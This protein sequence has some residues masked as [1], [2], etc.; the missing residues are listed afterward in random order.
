MTDS[1]THR[2]TLVKSR[3]RHKWLVGV[4]LFLLI[5]LAA[6]AGDYAGLLRWIGYLAIVAGVVGRIWASIYVAGRKNDE[7]VALGPYSVVRNPLYVFSFLGVAG[8]GLAT[9]MASVALLLTL[10]FA[11][12]YPFVIR[13]EERFLESRFGDTYRAYKARVP[14]WFPKMSLWESPRELPIRLDL[15]WKTTR[16]AA[17]WFLL[18][19]AFALLHWVYETGLA[20][21]L[22]RLP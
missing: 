11:V 5:L 7:V 18:P 15:V 4:P 17:W 2:K 14:R 22:L 20:D 6:P 8:L 12:Y 19:P 16:D 1:A 9:G 21:P 10:L 3:M 13:G